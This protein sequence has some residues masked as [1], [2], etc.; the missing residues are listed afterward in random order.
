MFCCLFTKEKYDSHNPT[1]GL[2]VLFKE[3]IS[4]EILLNNT[5]ITRLEIRNENCKTVPNA[6]GTVS[7]LKTLIIYSA[8]ITKLPESIKNLI[9]LSE[10]R[11]SSSGLNTFPHN[12]ILIP[13]LT[14][15]YMQNNRITTLP[16]DIGCMKHLKVLKLEGNHIES[17]PDSIGGLESLEECYLNNNRL[18]EVPESLGLLVKLWQIALGG[19]KL[20]SLSSSFLTNTAEGPDRHVDISDNDGE[21]LVEVATTTGKTGTEIVNGSHLFGNVTL[22]G[23]FTLKYEPARPPK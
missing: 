23:R 20:S 3:M 1:H 18:S 12:I 17:L 19:N 4:S 15:L 6:L 2:L 10:L 7:N 22:S 5:D 16:N 14:H 8:F 21:V 9:F 11:M 13:Y